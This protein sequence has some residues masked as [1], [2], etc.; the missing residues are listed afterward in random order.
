MRE[1][2]FL[3]LPQEFI[4]SMKFLFDEKEYMDFLES[5]DQPRSF[6][7]RVNT[8]KVSQ[9]EFLKISPFSLSKIPWATDGYYFRGRRAGKT[10]FIFFRILL[11]SG[12]KRHVTC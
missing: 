6:G 10:F 3:Q 9:E 8:L 2:F 5:F 7:L 1:A 12:A 11:Y 4:Q